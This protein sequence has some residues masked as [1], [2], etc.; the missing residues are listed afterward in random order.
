[1]VA[2]RKHPHLGPHPYTLREGA[3]RDVY[4]PRLVDMVPTDDAVIWEDPDNAVLYDDCERCSQHADHPL[5]SLDNDH[6]RP[7]IWAAASVPPTKPIP[8][9]PT[10]TQTRAV[11]NLREKWI[12][13]ISTQQ[14]LEQITGVNDGE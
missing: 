4:P 5:S 7:L 10:A 13:S 2:H 3:D 14:R 6:L 1:M 12:E 11:V 8:P 9:Q